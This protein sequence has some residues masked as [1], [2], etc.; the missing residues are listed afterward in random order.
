MP[1]FI[2]N[3]RSNN[4]I[5]AELGCGGFSRVYHGFHR[6]TDAEVAVKKTPKC[7]RS[8]SDLVH[9]QH[10]IKVLRLLSHPNCVEIY[11]SFES[12]R[13]FYIVMSFAA[14]GQVLLFPLP[15]FEL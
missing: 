5:C 6:I 2:L 11:G 4:S 13:N 14:G 7:N 15:S 3:I 9:W 1:C 8:Q 12:K 10:E